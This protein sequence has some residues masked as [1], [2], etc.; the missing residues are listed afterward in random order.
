MKIDF[1]RF[2]VLRLMK[3]KIKLFLDIN[4]GA[5][6]IVSDRKNKNKYKINWLQNVC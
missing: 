5:S 1:K 2:K 3:S 6:Q 4:Q